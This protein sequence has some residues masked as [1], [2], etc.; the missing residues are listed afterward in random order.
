MKRLLNL[1]TTHPNSIG[2][3]YVQHFFSATRISGRLG[4]ACL[5]QFTHAVLP[6]IHPPFGSDTRSL[7]LFLKELEP[8]NRSK[9]AAN[10]EDLNDNFGSD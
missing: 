1:F 4:I 10:I 3:T 2:E 7:T 6:F 9:L 5:S 8:K